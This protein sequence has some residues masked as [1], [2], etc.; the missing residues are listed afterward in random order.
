MNLR[1]GSA[2]TAEDYAKLRERWIDR[3]TADRALLR[4]V[5]SI[6]GARIVGRNGACDFAGLLI[7]N[8]WP[9]TDYA[10]E[11]RLRRDRPDMENGKPKMKYVAPP[12]KGN[13]LYF[14]AGS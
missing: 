1:E 6:E 5:P 4:R 9:G 11:F 8:V 10:R 12:G 3:Q 14:A 13:L 2:M 7:P